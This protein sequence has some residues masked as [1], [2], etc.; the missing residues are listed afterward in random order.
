MGALVAVADGLPG[1]ARR[2]AA[3]W[4]ERVASDR[5]HAAAAS[6]IGALTASDEA[7]ASVFDEVVHLVTARARRN[8]LVSTS[9]AGRQPYRALASYGPEDADLFVG[10]ERLVAELA[11]R[12]LDRRLVAVV[13]ASGS[14]KSS[15]VRAGLIPLVRSGQLPGGAPW[16]TQVVVPGRDPLA[17][18]DA[19]ADLDEPGPQLLVVDQFEEAL[20]G[21]EADAFASRL[22]D[23]VL[24][25]AL[26][27]HV[28][29]VVRADQYATLATSHGVSPNSSRTPR[30]SSVRRRARNCSGSSRCPAQ[31]TG[32]VVEPGL[33]DAHRRR[34]RRSRRAAV[35]LGGPRRGV[36]TA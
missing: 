5:L 27:V 4:A 24:D 25:A 11:A 34:R 28:V 35:G 36:G 8:E 9:W 12:V 7:R 2:E 29:I 10:R 19:V 20:A 31:R 14:G 3:A 22:V 23:L 21:D 13:G 32:C 17:A 16:R 30:C 33:V 1:V 26:D 18:L 15:L 6:A